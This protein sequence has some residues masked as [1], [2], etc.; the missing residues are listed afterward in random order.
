[1]MGKLSLRLPCLASCAEPRF[2][3]EHL[4]EWKQ[5]PK[6]VTQCHPKSERMDSWDASGEE[7]APRLRIRTLKSGMAKRTSRKRK[8][9]QLPQPGSAQPHMGAASSS[10]PEQKNIFLAPVK[11]RQNSDSDRH[12]PKTL[13][14]RP[15]HV[16]D[17]APTHGHWSASVVQPVNELDKGSPSPM[18][19]TKAHL[20][21]SALVV[22][23]ASDCALFDSAMIALLML[24]CKL[25]V[26]FASEECPKTREAL[27]ANSKKNASE[28]VCLWVYFWCIGCI[29][30]CFGAFGCIWVRLGLLGWVI[31]VRLGDVGCIWFYLDVLSVFEC[32]VGFLG[33][34]G[35]GGYLGVS[36]YTA[37]FS[38]LG[39]FWVHSSIWI[40]VAPCGSSWSHVY[41]FWGVSPIVAV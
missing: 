35:F 16:I 36:G 41:E 10:A 15:P 1:M 19:Y 32:V 17:Q 4:V 26:V 23:V 37:W 29:W 18:A 28:C 25:T 20:G 7:Q 22:K 6:T 27:K 31:F 30:L 34:S 8:A 9:A 33:V 40:Y 2:V 38:E 14:L 13:K 5:P 21:A 12:P 11:A 24:R 3:N 39:C